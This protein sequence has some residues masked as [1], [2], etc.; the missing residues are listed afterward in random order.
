MY[1]QFKLDRNDMTVSVQKGFGSATIGAAI[2]EYDGHAE[3]M[4]GI[5]P[6]IQ[7]GHGRSQSVH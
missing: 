6:L 3:W 1:L 2:Q 5:P 4:R 7:R